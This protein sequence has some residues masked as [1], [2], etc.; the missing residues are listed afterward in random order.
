MDVDLSTDLGALLPLVAPLISG[1]LRPG[2]RLPAGARLAGRPRRQARVH[3][4]RLQPDPAR[5]AVRALLRRAVRLQGDPRRR[6]ARGCCRWWRTPAGSSTP[7]CWS[8]PSGPGCASTR[9]RWTGSTTRTAGST[10]SRP[11]SADLQ[12]HRPAHPRAGH[13]PAAAGRPARATRP[14]PAAGRRGAGR[15]APA[16]CSGSPRSGWPA[17]SRTWLLFALLRTGAGP[18]WANLIALL[19]DGGGEHGRQPA[20]HLRRTRQRPR[21]ATPGAGSGGLR[22]R[23]GPDQRLAGAAGRAAR[24]TAQRSNWRCWSLAN[25]VAT[26]VRFLLMRI[27]VF[28]AA[29]NA[30]AVLA[31]RMTF[32]PGR[33]S[34]SE[35]GGETAS[36]TPVGR[37]ES[38]PGTFCRPDV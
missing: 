35:A 6:R 17:R 29:R 33:T 22:D 13:R 5:H 18:Q 16:S 12:G 37:R 28:R 15:A 32:A 25:L 30:R 4:P 2:D 20:A 38:A 21:L 10:S 19:V 26:G 8:W 14:Q 7:R 34:W 24:P 23:T 3:L 1:P 27:W 9:C 36:P 11:R 31:G